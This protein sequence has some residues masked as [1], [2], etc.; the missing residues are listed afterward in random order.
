[1]KKYFIP[2]FLIAFFWLTSCVSVPRKQLSRMIPQSIHT[3][4]KQAYAM[5]ES[6]RTDTTR[7]PRSINNRGNLMTSDSRWWC[8]G[9]FPG[10]LWY[11][12]ELTGQDSL[13]VL[14]ESFT[15]R[16]EREKFTTNNHD[17]GFM[18]YCS[19][20]NGYR[21]T[22]NASYPEVMLTAARSLSTRY[23]PKIGLIRSW[24]SH[25][26]RWQYRVIV[27]NMMNLGLVMWTPRYS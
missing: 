10:S 14:A 12:Y 7:L 13:R 26:Q 17:V 18:I 27:D 16:V 19:F 6:L 25:K 20:G 2:L 22:R 3:A 11:L 21:L 4:V 5:A 8:S 23:N 9:F 24:D 15:R 1:M